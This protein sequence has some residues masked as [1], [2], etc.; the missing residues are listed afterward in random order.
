MRGVRL[1][2]AQRRVERDRL[3]DVPRYA[4]TSDPRVGVEIVSAAL[5]CCSVSG[6]DEARG[7][8]GLALVAR[9]LSLPSEEGLLRFLTVRSIR[10]MNETLSIPLRYLLSSKPRTYFHLWALHPLLGAEGLA[11]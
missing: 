10:T 11:L 7:G 2:R 6:P 1:L 5:A 8:G 4:L 3:L 9:L